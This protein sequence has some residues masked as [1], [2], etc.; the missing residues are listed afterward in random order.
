MELI[1]SGADKLQTYEQLL[2]ERDR[3]VKEA[4]QIWTLYLRLFGARINAVFEEKIECIKRKKTIAYCQTIL[5]HGGTVDGA[6][7]N[8][9]LDQE[10][11]EYYRQLKQMM[12]DAETSRKARTVSAYEAERFRTLYRCLAKLLH[13]DMHPA[14][15]QE[16]TL[17]DL[18]QRIMEAYHHNDIKEL[19]E[20]EILTR[21]ALQALGEDAVRV[22]V[23][24]ID[25][26]IRELEDEI[27]GI[28]ST[29]PYTYKAL[30]E[31]DAAIRRK[32]T[33]LDE[34]L[35]NYRRYRGELDAVID[36]MLEG[37]GIILQWQMN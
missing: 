11:A 19:S 3:L 23:P 25:D 21:K 8:Q 36:R 28:K 5:N 6:A 18:W 33:E 29:E 26:R 30:V 2:L 34:E 12:A 15:D 35:A 20:L 37:G 24:D 7:L 17:R 9:Y 27:A 32:Q 31:D 22:E 13:P 1:T 14:T 10:M 4:G 16:E